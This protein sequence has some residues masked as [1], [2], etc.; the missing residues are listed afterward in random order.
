MSNLV[1][2][3]HAELPNMNN[4][5]ENLGSYEIL[6]SSVRDSSRISEEIGKACLSLDALSCSDLNSVL[7]AMSE[8]RSRTINSSEVII[9]NKFHKESPVNPRLLHRVEEVFY[10]NN[11]KL[12]FIDISPL[13]P[14]G[15]NTLLTG[16]SEKKVVA[17]LRGSEANADPTT[18]LFRYAYSRVISSDSKNTVRLATNSRSVRAQN[19]GENSKLFQHFKTFSEVTVG[20]HDAHYG[21]QELSSLIDHVAY[22]TR[23][24][25]DIIGGDN[26]RVYVSNLLFTKE[27]KDRGD[28]NLD[29]LRS[30]M[31][32]YNKSDYTNNKSATL[33]QKDF[34]EKCLDDLELYK[35]RKLFRLFIDLVE[36]KHPE[37]LDVLELD[38]NRVAGINYYRHM[39]YKIIGLRADG[40]PFPLGDGGTT[41]WAQKVGSNKQLYTVTS[42]VG[43]EILAQ[44]FKNQENTK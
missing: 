36:E 9:G 22:E 17:S 12:E 37:L 40:E 11:P 43:T 25:Q 41:D 2:A 24:L 42:G 26:I 39:C 28:I 44:Q 18:A 34:V 38:I 15:I 19:F 5:N 7:I 20:S 32:N 35:G 31:R 27:L 8:S 21:R 16:T 23:C 3:L 29:I 4:S 6:L 10:G 33:S 13:Q 30:Q 14:F 1:Q